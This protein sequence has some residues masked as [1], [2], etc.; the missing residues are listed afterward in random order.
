MQD[1]ENHSFHFSCLL[2]LIAFMGWREPP[3]TQFPQLTLGACRAARYSNLWESN[4]QIKKRNNVIVFYEYYNMLLEAIESTPR[5]TTEVVD[6]YHSK[7]EF[8][9]DRHTIYLRSRGF[10]KNNEWAIGL[11]RM[12]A[13]EVEDVIKLLMMT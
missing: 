11:Y 8:T 3:H 5:L 7:L 9:V 6:L 2:I 10:K 13:Q 12:T 1:E 4:N